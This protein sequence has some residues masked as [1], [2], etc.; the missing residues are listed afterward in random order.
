MFKVN[1]KSFKQS[2]L[3]CLKFNILDVSVKLRKTQSQIIVSLQ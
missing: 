3:L 1:V 2:D